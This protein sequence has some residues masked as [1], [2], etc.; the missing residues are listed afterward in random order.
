MQPKLLVN[1]QVLRFIAAA[2]VLYSHIKHEAVEKKV[3]GYEYMVPAGWFSGAFGVDIF[4]VISGFIMIIISHDEKRSFTYSLLF[5]RNR[6]IR[7]VPLYWLFTILM[8][9]SMLIFSTHITHK[10]IEPLHVFA[11]FLF[12]PWPNGEGELNPILGVGWTLNYEM[13]FYLL[14]SVSTLFSGAKRMIVLIGMILG[15]TALSFI[16]DYPKTSAL[17]FWAQPIVIEF[18]Y[19]CFIGLIFTRGVRI[20]LWASVGLSVV[21]AIGIVYTSQENWITPAWRFASAGLPALAITAGFALGPQLQ[22]KSYFIEGLKVTGDASYAL[23]LS[24][25]FTVNVVIVLWVHYSMNSI[26][27][28][29]LT[30][31]VASVAVSIATHLLIEMP[32]LKWAHRRSASFPFSARTYSQKR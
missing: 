1:I 4:F 14:F 25:P 26:F 21:G 7:I 5:M 20:P 12:L 19:G 3:L 29:V 27:A 22:Q 13:Y 15:M 6:V 18:L 28:L 8:L 24:H 23:Y 9:L 32:A 30:T 16:I 2:L 31:F 17:G 11:S 10:K